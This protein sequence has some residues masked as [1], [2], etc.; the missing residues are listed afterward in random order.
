MPSVAALN[1]VTGKTGIVLLSATFKQLL[2]GML[3]HQ[4]YLLRDYPALVFYTNNITRY[5]NSD[6]SALKTVP[7]NEM[8]E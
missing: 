2:P 3:S 1:A 5:K 7:I 6:R 8:K 4:N